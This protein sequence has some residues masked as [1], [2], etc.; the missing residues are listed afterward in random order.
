MAADPTIRRERFISWFPNKTTKNK[1][2][3][4]QWAEDIQETREDPVYVNVQ[5][6]REYAEGFKEN[7]D[8]A[9]YFK[10]NNLDAAFKR[11]KSQL[12]NIE[13]DGR[14]VKNEHGV[15]FMP[16]ETFK[17]IARYMVEGPSAKEHHSIFDSPEDQK[18]GWEKVELENILHSTPEPIPEPEEKEE[19]TPEKEKKEESDLDPVVDVDVG[20]SESKPV[21]LKAS[22]KPTN[23]LPKGASIHTRIAHQL[24]K[25]YLSQ[26]GH[27]E[28]KV[29]DVLQK[30]VKQDDFNSAEIKNLDPMSN[31]E[32]ADAVFDVISSIHGEDGNKLQS[33]ANSKFNFLRSAKFSPSLLDTV[34]KMPEGTLATID[35]LKKHFDSQGKTLK[36]L[37]GSPETPT[38]VETPTPSGSDNPVATPTPVPMDAKSMEA[39]RQS[40]I[41]GLGD[42][43]ACKPP[44]S[45][46]G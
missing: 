36:E 15:K 24:A 27:Y 12:G 34:A 41:Q 38:P 44:P 20:S 10:K 19:P 31:K 30:Y 25:E 33:W 5:A 23:D 46:F 37:A 35:T 1:V 29:R 4:S 32:H 6:L 16:L 18:T 28:K 13:A 11:N 17:K 3:I 14:S 7:S 21:F 43:K 8:K 9:V 26:G 22:G 40:I 2:N 39:F 42:N 45:V